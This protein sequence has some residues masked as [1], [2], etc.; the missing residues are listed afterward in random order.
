MTVVISGLLASKYNAV[1]RLERIVRIKYDDSNRKIKRLRLY[2]D[3]AICMFKK[4]NDTVFEGI[5]DYGFAGE[6]LGTFT[7]NE[8]ILDFEIMNKTIIAISVSKVYYIDI[9]DYHSGNDSLIFAQPTSANNMIEGGVKSNNIKLRKG[10]GRVLYFYSDSIFLVDPEDRSLIKKIAPK[11]SLHIMEANF[12]GPSPTSIGYV[13]TV[14]LYNWDVGTRREITYID[15]TDNLATKQKLP[16]NVDALEWD[17]PEDPYLS[18]PIAYETDGKK[19]SY[20]ALI[21]GD[22]IEMYHD[23]TLRCRS[24]FRVPSGIER[25]MVDEFHV[26]AL[27]KSNDIYIY[28]K[29]GDRVDSITL[30]SNL[31]DMDINNAMLN[32][33]DEDGYMN[34]Y[35]LID[36]PSLNVKDI[37]FERKINEG[38]KE[39]YSYFMNTLVELSIGSSYKATDGAAYKVYV[40]NGNDQAFE[41]MYESGQNKNIYLPISKG[42]LRTLYTNYREN[43]MASAMEIYIHDI[44]TDV[45]ILAQ[46]GFEDNGTTGNNKRNLFRNAKT[47]A[48]WKMGVN[49]RSTEDTVEILHPTERR[50]VEILTP[51]SPMATSY[52][53]S[54]VPKKNKN[55]ESIVIQNISNTGIGLTH[56]MALFDNNGNGTE[57]SIGKYYTLSFLLY[58]TNVESNNLN[59]PKDFTLAIFDSKSTQPISINLNKN[60]AGRKYTRYRGIIE[61][62]S[63]TFK[64]NDQSEDMIANP[65][66]GFG[67]IPVS[68]G[69]RLSYT[70]AGLTLNE[71]IVEND[72]VI[73][74]I[75]NPRPKG[76]AKSKS[77]VRDIYLLNNELYFRSRTLLSGSYIKEFTLGGY[78]S[79]VDIPITVVDVTSRSKKVNEKPN[80]IKRLNTNYIDPMYYTEDSLGFD[81][82]HWYK[83][84]LPKDENGNVDVSKLFRLRVTIFSRDKHEYQTSK[85]FY[86]KDMIQMVNEKDVLVSS[87]DGS[88]RKIDTE[89]LSDIENGNKDR[90]IS[91]FSNISF[92]RI[93][94]YPTIYISDTKEVLNGEV[95]DGYLTVPIQYDE[96]QYKKN[97]LIGEIYIGGKK[98]FRKY[99]R[100]IDNLE[101]G[102]TLYY[103]TELLKD[104]V[105]PAEFQR[106]SRGGIPQSEVVI[107]GVKKNLIE[108]ERLL[109]KHKFSNELQDET[110]LIS[111][112]GMYIPM[113]IKDGMKVDK[114]RIFIRDFGSDYLVRVNPRSYRISL[115]KENQQALVVIKGSTWISPGAEMYIVSNGVTDDSIFYDKLNSSYEVD[116][117]PLIN[118]DSENNVYTGLASRA[119]D[120]D[121]NVN[122][123]TLVPGFDYSV[124]EPKLKHSPTLV[125]FR[126]VLPA[127]SKIEINFLNKGTNKVRTFRGPAVG[128]TNKFTMEDDSLIFFP[129]GFE[130]FANNLKVPRSKVQILDSKTIQINIP[131]DQLIN[132]MVR[133][134][135][136]DH[137]NLKEIFDNY[138]YNLINSTSELY[139]SKNALSRESNFDKLC[140]GKVSKTASKLS[141]LSKVKARKGFIID[142]NKRDNDLVFDINLD[143]KEIF[144][145]YMTENIEIDCNYLYVNDKKVE[146]VNPEI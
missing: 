48:N 100:Q 23:S 112:T 15:S 39:K 34:I 46:K 43:N 8:D 60:S 136:E 143:A 30:N 12:I 88:I 50:N 63:F 105:S 21:G 59:R 62:H 86:I 83:M 107:T 66:V 81:K 135:Y 55:L 3:L 109:G 18:S 9:V 142:A 131:N 19:Y 139:H 41:Y 70:L 25:L 28:D 101:G 52:P 53:L 89:Y 132:V 104:V 99:V 102:L 72:E 125:L 106:M 45:K 124:I 76:I 10:R 56:E 130:V 36:V 95:L 54:L 13:D 27:G 118:F 1:N 67:I 121:V 115:D 77:E 14:E 110:E 26:V 49:V 71:G 144:N 40:T 123:Y 138:K 33:I 35:K 64:I 134:S 141:L 145:Q 122:G 119:E 51:S 117:V 94:D 87:T 93:V 32:V 57:I 65:K 113:K 7:I 22:V 5:R 11:G 116:S 42:N 31:I 146:F 79:E 44:T 24:L 120:I 82:F 73:D 103:P 80:L 127:N 47:F 133:F 98:A 75:E 137:P 6:L 84:V 129:N 69:V 68:D 74:D 20:A 29:R 85:E 37:N 92:E 78:D 126:N 4:G 58:V 111:T 108:S 91:N 16:M 17:Y 2:S 90:Y 128:T 38:L 114:M 96:Y 97:S 140:K 61:R